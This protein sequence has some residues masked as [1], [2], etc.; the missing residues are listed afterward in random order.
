MNLRA[1]ALAAAACAAIGL[2]A[3]ETMSAEECAAADWRALGFHDAAQTGS[4]RFASRSESCAEKGFAADYNAYQ[5]GIQEGLYEFCQ[6][7]RAF[8]FARNGGSFNGTCPGEL[9]EDFSY[10]FADGQR[11]NYAEA[12]LSAAESEVSRLENERD[13]LDEDIR[14]R[15]RTI[16]NSETTREA[17]EQAERELD[18]FRRRRRDINDDIRVAQARIP[19]ARRALDNIRYEIGNRWGSW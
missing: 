4:D 5:T 1:M 3:C 19:D 10:A 12:A 17:R 13:R 15:E 9:Q 18:Q 2:A 11:V 14:S 8:Y 6:P 7:N 16:A